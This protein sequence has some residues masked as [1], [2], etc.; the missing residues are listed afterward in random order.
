MPTGRPTVDIS[1]T[2]TPGGRCPACGQPLFGWMEAPGSDPGDQRLHVMDRCENCRLGLEREDAG[3]A[4]GDLIE[5]IEEQVT[6]AGEATLE[7]AN[8]TSVQAGIGA[9][10][11]SA[12]DL[13]A[14]PYLVNPKALDLLLEHEQLEISRLSYPMRAAM[15]AMMLTLLN[16]ITFNRNFAAAALRGRLHPSTARPGP[17]AYFVDTAITALAA[18][19]VA[20][21]SVV[22]EGGASLAR[23]GGVLRATIRRRG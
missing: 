14:E 2:A 5:R 21:I 12:L 19:P 4:L 20:I 16:L 7:V 11:W 8:G 6:K 10:N 23:R 18:I 22:L 9:E 1:D 15:A 13:P 3:E 17:A